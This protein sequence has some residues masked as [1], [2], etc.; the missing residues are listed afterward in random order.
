MPRNGSGGYSLPEAPFVSGTLI[1]SAS[2]NNDLNDIAN[3]LTG[4]L[5]ADG[6]TPA[7]GALNMNTHAITGVTSLTTT[8]GVTV[9]GN[10]S[11][12]G[13]SGL[14]GNLAV[15]GNFQVTAA[16]G[17]VASN[18]SATFVGTLG[19]GGAASLSSTLGVTKA[20]LFSSTVAIVGDV[21]VNTNKFTVTAASGNTTIAGTLGVTGA[22]TFSSTGAFT[23]VVTAA[24][25]STGSRVVNF[26]QFPQ[27]TTASVSI[28]FPGAV[29]GGVGVY[30]QGGV[31]TS[32][33]LGAGTVT[34]PVA[35]PTDC[36]SCVLTPFSAGGT[37][38]FVTVTALSATQ[39]SFTV[40]DSSG[41][42]VS[43]IS[44]YWRAIGY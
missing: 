12:A 5:A 40:R 22:A 43:G 25:G 18:G 27:T 23:G 29:G 17:N 9:G 34:F 33:L 26:S 11:V 10:L 20:A 1:T 37:A 39:V 19:V 31:G 6:Q 7:T 13:T 15:G 32:S 30:D 35:F 41:T 36:K 3:A 44:V 42:G 14:T 4:S 28:G 8:A 2:M 38:Y 24:A 21:A 16:S